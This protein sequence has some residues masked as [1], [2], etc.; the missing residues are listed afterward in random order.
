[1]LLARSLGMDGQTS[2]YCV[3]WGEV[4][5]KLLKT[6]PR[7]KSDNKKPKI[8]KGPV[9]SLPKMKNLISSVVIDFSS[10]SR[11]TLLLRIKGGGLISS[12]FNHPY[13][14]LVQDYNCPC[15]VLLKSVWIM[16]KYAIIRSWNIL[17]LFCYKVIKQNN[18][19]EISWS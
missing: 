7:L 9:L 14:V 3:L 16:I 12:V 2:F 11:N 4:L 17:S 6:I 10:K 1:M 18:I 13:A 5:E 8:I 19:K 15:Y